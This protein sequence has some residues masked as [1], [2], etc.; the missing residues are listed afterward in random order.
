MATIWFGILSKPIGPDIVSS[1]RCIENIWPNSWQYSRMGSK[2]SSVAVKL[3]L[4]LLSDENFYPFAERIPAWSR[5]N[6]QYSLL[7]FSA[8]VPEATNTHTR[9]NQTQ[10]PRCTGG[11]ACVLTTTTMTLTLTKADRQRERG[12]HCHHQ[13]SSP[14]THHIAPPKKKTVSVTCVRDK[15]TVCFGCGK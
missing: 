3:L 7:L 4:G 14:H 11:C 1:S 8:E 9:D 13:L 10:E 5:G 12:K 2:L 15:A 6:L